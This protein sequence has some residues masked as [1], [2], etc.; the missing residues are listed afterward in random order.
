MFTWIV[1]RFKGLVSRR[2]LA[3]ETAPAAFLDL[4]REMREL[5][6]IAARVWPEE[7]AFQERI[8]SI[9]EEMDQLDQLTSKP[10][11]RLLPLK[12][13]LELRESLLNSKTQLM[14]TVS[15]AP[16]P[17]SRPQ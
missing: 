15:T 1:N 14:D 8:R 17:T 7:A 10:E 13:R 11:F 16:A 12:K 2:R 9:R 4:S 5:A 6:G 3:R